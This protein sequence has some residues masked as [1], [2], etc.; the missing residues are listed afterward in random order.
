MRFSLFKSTLFKLPDTRKFEYVPRTEPPPTLHTKTDADTTLRGLERGFI[1]TST[2]SAASNVK[3]PGQL[4]RVVI[5]ILI[6]V[7]PGFLFLF[8]ESLLAII[9]LIPLCWILFRS[10]KSGNG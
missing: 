1:S 6:L 2:D 7:V 10:I 3:A 5:V 4:Y 8:D 9:S